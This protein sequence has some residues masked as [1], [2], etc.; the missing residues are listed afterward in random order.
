MRS[1]QSSGGDGAREQVASPAAGAGCDGPG[2]DEARDAAAPAG[3]GC[4]GVGAGVFSAVDAAGCGGLRTPTPGTPGAADGGDG[5]DGGSAVPAAAREALAAIRAGIAGLRDLPLWM[6]GQDALL[7]LTGQ[8]ETTLRSAYGVQ[9]RL[10]GEIQQR[11]LAGMLDVRSAAHLLH[12]RLAITIGDARSRVAAAATG[13]PGETATGD[14][15]PPAV[16]GLMA[17]I[18]T[19]RVS[20]GHARVITDCLAKIPDGTD[21]E[22]RESCRATLLAQARQRDENA[23]ARVAEQI[24]LI[25]DPDGHLSGKDPADRAELHLGRQRSDG[26]TPIRG[27]L[28]QLTAEQLRVAIEALAGPRPVDAA[29]PDPRPPALRRAQALG[30]ILHRYL[31]CGAGPRDGGVRP[32]VVI[33][34]GIDDLIGHP[35]P[36][37]HHT[38]N[39]DANRDDHGDRDDDHTD[40]DGDDDS[41]DGDDTR[42]DDDHGDDIGDGDVGGWRRDV[43]DLF[44][45]IT[46]ATTGSAGA[47]GAG[48]GGRSAAASAAGG[49]AWLDYTGVTDPAIAR[50]LACDAALIRQVLGADS[51]VLDQGR[52]TRL[53]TAEQRR[54]ITTR[55]KGCGFP[56]CD[57]PPAWCEAHHIIWWSLDGTTDTTKGVLL[58]RRHHVLIHQG[59][60]SIEL[61]PD[62]GRPWFIP[63]AHIDPDRKPRRNNHF[64]LP[65][66]LTTIKRQ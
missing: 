27:L 33:T 11:G 37:C 57:T 44:A 26:L 64:H 30:E 14:T 50:L 61:D 18:D 47:A 58:C 41:A 21:E 4:G 43:V 15:I 7:D 63:P 39:A 34:I 49:F 6:V 20:A 31:T 23:L 60:W 51:V 35:P 59:R 9:V 25:L 29:T 45:R 56:N 66:L 13:L 8:V 42:G 54:A 36:G 24:R 3:D 38:D 40:A 19:G 46:A 5:G 2:G 32:Q 48:A 1:E 53:F 55:D 16:P 22:T 17:A 62:G 12:E 10:A 65:D 28:D 52:A